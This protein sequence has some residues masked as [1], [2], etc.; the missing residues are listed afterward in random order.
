MDRIATFGL[1][2]TGLRP[3]RKANDIVD[4][5]VSKTIAL[6]SPAPGVITRAYRSYTRKCTSVYVLRGLGDTN[7]IPGFAMGTT[8]VDYRAQTWF[9]GVWTRCPRKLWI[10]PRELGTPGFEALTQYTAVTEHRLIAVGREEPHALHSFPNHLVK[11]TD[12]QSPYHE[13]QVMLL[14]I[15]GSIFYSRRNPTERDTPVR[16]PSLSSSGQI[17]LRPHEPYHH[18][19]AV[20]K[21]YLPL[22]PAQTTA[23]QMTSDGQVNRFRCQTNACDSSSSKHHL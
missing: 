19:Q 16:A 21:W 22:L 18:Y 1:R 5:S 4:A 2:K 6:L 12:C 8:S 20:G 23:K 9:P 11:H 17:L 14:Y 7:G 3:R 10:C 13:L 15:A